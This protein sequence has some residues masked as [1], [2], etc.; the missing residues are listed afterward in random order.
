MRIIKAAALYF[1]IVFG[2]AF[3]FGVIRTLWVAPS[4]GETMAVLIE[5]PALIVVMA[6]TARWVP[7]ALNLSRSFIPLA[8]MGLLALL[9][10]QAGDFT[11]GL[12]VRGRSPADQL[13]YLLTPAGLIYVVAV[14]LFA[15]MPVLVNR[16]GAKE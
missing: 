9:L 2:A 13:A 7:Y 14:L 8:A 4:V 5:V 3:V 1:A 6:I 16:R 12:L 15:A 11:V 10:Q